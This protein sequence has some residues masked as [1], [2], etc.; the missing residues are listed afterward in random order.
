MWQWMSPEQRPA[1][2][3]GGH[4]GGDV[5]AGG[6][7]AGK[8]EG[9][10]IHNPFAPKRIVGQDGHAVG[11]ETLSVTR[12][13]DERGRF[14]PQLQPDSEKMWEGDSIIISLGHT[15]ECTWRT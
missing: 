4:R 3:R 2:G 13:F 14:N 9:I 1:W 11:L 12:A 8:G 5:S 15:G 10:V 6:V 7:R